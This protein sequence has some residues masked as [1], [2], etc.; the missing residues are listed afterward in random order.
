MKPLMVMAWDT[1]TP[2]C[3]AALAKISG[4]GVETLAE[5]KSDDG[6]HSKLLPPQVESMLKSNNLA[7]ADLDLLA[8][9][10]GPGSFTGLRTG[11]AL[12]K[13][14]ALGSGKPLMGLSSLDILAAEMLWPN[15]SASPGC[16]VAPVIDARH[17]EV[18][19]ALYQAKNELEL[20]C[21]MSPRP[22]PPDQL[23]AVL[24]E[25]APGRTIQVA[26]PA[27]DLV[28]QTGPASREIVFGPENLIP[29]ALM[30]ARLAA[31]RFVQERERALFLNPPLPLY[32]R[33]PDIRNSG[34]AMR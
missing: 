16:L 31:H 22:L 3:T 6:R 4:N 25:A 9:G 23:A 18:F 24:A 14:L 11:L 12:A 21:L 10:R 19:T 32:I 27:L 26:G 30:L 33:Q 34:L 7:P 8:V 2:W 28:K 17:Q 5:F 13:G 1:A 20:E 15:G 29:R